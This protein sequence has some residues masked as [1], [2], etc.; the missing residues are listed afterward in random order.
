MSFSGAARLQR[1]ESG[2]QPDRS[3]ALTSRESRN[4]TFAGIPFL[5]LCETSIWDHKSEN[6][7]LRHLGFHPYAAIVLLDNALTYRQT[8]AGARIFL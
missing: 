1:I 6:R 7:S 4:L 5:T 8:Q 3:L 2:V